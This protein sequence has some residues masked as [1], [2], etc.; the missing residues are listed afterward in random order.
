MAQ[1]D[2]TLLLQMV[3]IFCNLLQDLEDATDDFLTMRF[4]SSPAQNEQLDCIGE[5]VNEPRLG[6][7][8]VDYTTAILARIEI[9]ASCGE[10]ERLIAATLQLTQSVDVTL[11][12]AFPA[13]VWIVFVINASYTLPPTL[14]QSLE[15]VC[16]A[17]VKLYLMGIDSTEPFTFDG[18]Y[19]WDVGHLGALYT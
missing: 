12:P 5:I 18:T 3:E 17:G 4:I 16:A 13:G 10:P 11:I 9:N 1:G 8:D 2:R 15:R 14:F 19:G 6:R 7:S